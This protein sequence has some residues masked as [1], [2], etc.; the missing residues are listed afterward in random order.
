MPDVS[1]SL[2]TVNCNCGTVYAIPHW[3]II[4]Q[5]PL[6]AQRKID[7]LDAR[8]SDKWVEIEHLEKVN[9]GLRG[10]LKRSKRINRLA[11]G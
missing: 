6:C 9:A 3:V 10:A 8:S 5:C 1:I 7:D 11:R 2:K 4:Y